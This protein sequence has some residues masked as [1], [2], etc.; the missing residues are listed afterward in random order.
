[1]PRRRAM[2]IMLRTSISGRPTRLSSITSRSARRRLVAS[3][4]H[5]RRSGAASVASAA[6]H[7][8]AGDLL[9]R[10]ATAQRVGAGQIDQ[11]NAA[12]RRRLQHAGFAFDGDAGVVRNL[13]PAAGQRVEQGGL[14]AVGGADERNVKATG[15]SQRAHL[16]ASGITDDGH[17]FAAPQRHRCIVDPHRDR[18]AAEP[19]LMQNFDAGAFDEAKL[20]QAAFQLLRRQAELVRADVNRVDM[21]AETALRLSQW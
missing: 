6:K 16:G 4:T 3:A 2:S 18:V 21:A 7:D 11:V 13:L 17:R 15:C 8:V 14:A 1:M 12:A 5:S 10:A 9:V 19:A 20:Q